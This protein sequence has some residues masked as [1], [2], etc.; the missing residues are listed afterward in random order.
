VGA[1]QN[2]DVGS[3]TTTIR[4]NAKY[5]SDNLFDTILIAV[6]C[7]IPLGVFYLIY[8]GCVDGAAAHRAETAAVDAVRMA[9][10]KGVQVLGELLE[11]IKHLRAAM[12]VIAGAEV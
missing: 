5:I 6:A 10:I 9:Q 7:S 4:A 2:T 8:R 11:E 3:L 1:E 12:E